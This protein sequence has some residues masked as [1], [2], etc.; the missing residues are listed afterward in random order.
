MYFVFII[1]GAVDF[2]HCTDGIII[3]IIKGKVL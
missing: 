1:Q 2:F 3:S